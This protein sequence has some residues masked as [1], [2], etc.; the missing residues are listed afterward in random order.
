MQLF[1]H[2]I[3]TG[4]GNTRRNFAVKIQSSQSQERLAGAVPQQQPSRARPS[5][6]GRGRDS[7]TR[8][9]GQLRAGA[10]HGAG[11]RRGAGLSPLL[12]CPSAAPRGAKTA[13]QPRPLP[14]GRVVWAASEASSRR[15]VLAGSGGA[16]PAAE[17][18]SRAGC[19]SHLAAALSRPFMRSRVPVLARPGPRSPRSRS[20]RL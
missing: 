10:G 15:R 19:C 2:C 6:T 9:P 5:T 11:Q 1:S 16:R 4:L 8:L 20:L 12:L 7:V 17:P 3:D 13:R 14:G 18:F